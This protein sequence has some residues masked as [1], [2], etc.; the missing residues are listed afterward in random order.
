MPGKRL[1]VR[2]GVIVIHEGKVLLARQHLSDGQDFWIVPGGGL[3]KDE[4]LMDCARREIAEET[5]LEIEPL[6]LLYVGD[7]FKADRH[8]VDTFW[9]GRIVGGELRRRED[10]IDNLRFFEVQRLSQLDVKPPALAERLASDVRCGFSSETVYLG[11]Y[12]RSPGQVAADRE[13]PPTGERRT[14]SG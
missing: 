5:G 11:K 9:L 13:E 1:R 8:V 12:F 10:E 14:G 7:F 6:R 2:V 3:K 4:G